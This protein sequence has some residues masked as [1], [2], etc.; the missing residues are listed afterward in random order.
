MLSLEEKR[1]VLER[2]Y[3]PEHVIPLM[4]GLSGG[5]AHLLG[6]FLFFVGVDWLIMVGFPLRGSSSPELQSRLKEAE[7][8]FRPERLWFVGPKLPDFLEKGCLEREEDQ[9]FRLDLRTLRGA[10]WA[11]P[12]KL[13]RLVS[14][15]E[16]KF[17][18]ELKSS[19]DSP[20][21]QLT[22]ELLERADPGARVRE[23]YR[24]IPSYLEK[25][26]SAAL[27]SAWDSRGR[28]AA[29]SFLELAPPH[30]SVYVAG[31]SSRESW[32]A[33]ASDLL[34]REMAHI[35]IQENKQ[36]M[37]LGLGVNPGI[38]RFKRK[39]GGVPWMDYR[40]CGW[41]RPLSATRRFLKTLGGMG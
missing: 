40:A 8:R 13:K 3:I 6:D 28:L 5:E 29:Y 27:L 10:A 39:W 2:A 19:F 41:S 9:Y 23:L 34:V 31:A 20:H 1:F 12:G 38:S 32:A 33:H 16:Q 36:F 7:L 14:K 11:P 15:A 26:K 30:F 24:R 21:R 22:Q 18:V 35:T 37:H 25:T 17:S 4:E